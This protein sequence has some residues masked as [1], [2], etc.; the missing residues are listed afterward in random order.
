MRFYEIVN[1]GAD[2]SSEYSKVVTAIS[3][4][5]SE[6]QNKN[7]KPEVP[8]ERIITIAKNTGLPS[9]SYQDLLTVNDQ[10]PSM[11]NLVK[12]ISPETVTFATDSDQSVDNPADLATDAAENPQQ[13]VSNM[14]KQAATRRQKPLF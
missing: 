1:E 5:R 2:G 10:E 9:F 4:L 13:T 11:K 6:I 12:N 7:L 3:T 14:A 8:T